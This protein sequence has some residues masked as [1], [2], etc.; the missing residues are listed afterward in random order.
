MPILNPIGTENY[1]TSSENDSDFYNESD[2]ALNDFD[3][4]W[5][6][7]NNDID[8]PKLPDLLET[9]KY[10]NKESG[11]KEYFRKVREKKTEKDR[12]EF[13]FINLL[14][15]LD[16]KLNMPYYPQLRRVVRKRDGE[17]CVIGYSTNHK[18]KFSNIKCY[19]KRNLLHSS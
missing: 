3:E 18:G 13:E 1:S 11:Q 4:L 12:K 10:F 5:S 15:S 8:P 14:Y 2:N 6:E 17:F 7:I 16:L 9:S 19:F